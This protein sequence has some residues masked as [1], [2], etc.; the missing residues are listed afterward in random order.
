MVFSALKQDEPCSIWD[1]QI[2]LQ[3]GSN[4]ALQ[5]LGVMLAE[6]IHT[7]ITVNAADGSVQ[8]HRVVLA[9]RSPVFSSMFSYNNNVKEKDLSA[10]HIPD[11]SVEACLA[12]VNYLY[13][14]IKHEDFM[15][16]RLHL[17]HAAHKYDVPDL[18]EVCHESLFNDLNSKNVLDRLQKAFLYELTE[19]KMNCIKYL[20]N[21]GRLYDIHDDFKEFMEHADRDLITE[22]MDEIITSWR[23][24]GF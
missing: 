24:N 17:L 10:I 13:G 20:V 12:F 9:A 5:S 7:D 8:A 23:I 6:H 15:A 19:L 2:V 1:D 22:I 18:K 21:F 4:A 16:Y 14:S 11:M 3:N